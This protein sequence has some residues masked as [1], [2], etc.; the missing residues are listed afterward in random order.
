MKDWIVACV[1]VSVFA[2][3]L[4]LFCTLKKRNRSR[5]G[6]YNCKFIYTCACFVEFFNRMQI[7]RAVWLPWVPEVFFYRVRRGA[8]VSA[9]S[10]QR[11]SAQGRSNK[12]LDRDRNPR[13]KRLWHPRYS[14]VVLGGK[15]DWISVM[16]QLRMKTL[17]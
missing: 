14:L 1:A 16:I 17:H 2:V 3:I 4:A 7:N 9:A 5:K 13:M 12:P 10:R 8:P 15:W 6:R 11:S